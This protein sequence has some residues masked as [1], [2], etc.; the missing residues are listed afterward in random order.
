M[1]LGLTGRILIAGG[2]VGVFL[3]GQFIVLIVSFHSVRGHTRGEQ[4]AE[5]SVAAAQRV[6]K[7]ILDLETGLRGYA[8]TRDRA[9]LQPYVQAQRD[10]PG[11]SRLLMTLAPGAWSAD[12]DRRWRSYVQWA[13]PIVRETGTTPSR[14]RSQIASGE[15][16]RRID[17]M[18]ALIDPFVQRSS[19]LATRQRERVS[20][21]ERRG[22]R[23]GAIG[24]LVRA[25]A[26]G[27][28]LLYFLRAIV[29]PLR[30]VARATERVAKGELGV[31]VAE[32][33]VGEIGQ[34]KTAFNEMSRS[35]EGSRRSLAQ[36]NV[37]LERLANL[38]RAVLDSTIDG[39]L[40]SDAE[41]QM[42][43]ANRPLVK[44]TRDLGMDYNG[45]VV[46]RLLSVAHR[47][48]DEEKYREAMERLRTNSDEPTMD[49]FEDKVSGRVF[50]GFTAPVHDDRG[51]FIGRIWTLREVTQQRELDRLKDDFV[52]TVSHELRTPLTSMMGFLEMVREGEAGEITDEQKRFLDIVYRSSERLQR[53]VG[54]LLFV[55]RLDANG[56]QLQF[57]EAHIDAIVRD[58]LETTAALARSR[59]IAI[60][61]DLQDVPPIVGDRER[62]SQLVGN[63]VSNALKFTPA[64][65][66]VAARTFADGANVVIEI[67]DTGIGI[68]EGE[69]DRLFQRF[70]RSS[71]ATQ[72]AIPGTGLGLVISRAIAEAHGGAITVTS[73]SGE[74][75]CF[76]V[77]I[78][79][80]R[81][82]D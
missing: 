30:R 49:E 46:D 44:L 11:A 64:G 14:A 45:T 13:K 70:F 78:P 3:I 41:G 51:A 80:E 5:Q 62:L 9:F 72:Q 22:V 74:G 65:G 24:I 26:F 67:A 37:D 57:A 82:D 36:Q 29:G 4:H 20:A 53:L 7:L 71:T 10:L 56:L 58:T 25:L 61:S 23:L 60:E 47:V 40:L 31:R 33:G 19:V 16:K 32:K 54:D 1:R 68:P 17:R 55:A 77:E 79:I 43:L 8:L 35:L 6:E 28:G 52:A 63:L 21:D 15:G 69:Q 59:E 27:A 42:Q 81:E 75:T 66:S 73:K 76:R 2:I 39:I 38:L 48:V 18:R 50:Q 34:L 12:L